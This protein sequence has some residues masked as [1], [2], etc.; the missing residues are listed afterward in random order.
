M[1]RKGRKRGSAGNSLLCVILYLKGKSLLDEKTD[2]KRPTETIRQLFSGCILFEERRGLR[3]CWDR[4]INVGT[5][6][7]QRVC[8]SNGE[9]GEMG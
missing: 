8:Q 3:N 1:W 5:G 2:I 6:L 7:E 9:R 4:I